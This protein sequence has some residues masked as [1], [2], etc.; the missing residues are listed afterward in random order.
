MMDWNG[1]NRRPLAW[2]PGSF[3]V[4]FFMNIILVFI[5]LLFTSRVFS[6]PSEPLSSELDMKSLRDSQGSV[7]VKEINLALQSSDPV[8]KQLASLYIYGVLDAT[9]GSKW[10]NSTIEPID[11]GGIRELANYTLR[12]SLKEKPNAVAATVL[13]EQFHKTSPCENGK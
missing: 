13:I 4:N 11:P 6:E 7:S 1:F 10:C 5:L 9:E 2:K 8:E 12:K 3:I